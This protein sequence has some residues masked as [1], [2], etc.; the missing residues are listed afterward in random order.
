MV[1]Y[2]VRPDRADEN[3]ALVRA[4]YEQLDRERP[5]GLHYATFKLPDG[6]SFMHVVFETDEPGRILND[7]GAF[8]AFV[9]DIESRCEEPPVATELTVVGS[10]AFGSSGSKP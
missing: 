4:V 9:A 8:K 5:E 6:V 7:V 2:K 10:Y 1:R 3:E